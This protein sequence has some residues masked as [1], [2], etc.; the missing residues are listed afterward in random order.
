MKKRIISLIITIL[1]CMAASLP[2]FADNGSV[3]IKA[4]VTEYPGAVLHELIWTED[5]SR[6]SMRTLPMIASV[7]TKI[8][9]TGEFVYN[10][11]LYLKTIFNGTEGYIKGSTVTL[12][13]SA[14]G[15]DSAYKTAGPRSIAVIS[16]DGVSLRKGPSLAYDTVSEPFG[17]GT[18]FT[19]EYVDTEYEPDARWAYVT[20]DDVSGWVYI[21]Q[22]AMGI[23]CD[24]AKVLSENDYYTGKIKTIT[25]GAYLTEMPYSASEKVSENIPEKT[26]FDFKYYYENYDSI[27]VF[28]EYDG[29]KGWIK[30][31]NSEDYKAALGVKSGVCVFKEGGLPIYTD[32]FDESSITGSSLSQNSIAS[33]DYT[34]YEIIKENEETKEKRWMH[35]CSDDAEGWICSDN[36]NDYGQLFSVADYIISNEEGVTLYAEPDEASDKVATVPKDGVVTVFYEKTNLIEDEYITW[37][38]TEYNGNGGWMLFKAENLEYIEG[39]EAFT[40]MPASSEEYEPAELTESL[41]DLSSG[42]QKNIKVIAAVA[43]VCVF[44]A[45]I[46]AVIVIIIRKK[47]KSKAEK[48]GE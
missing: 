15:Q 33:V 8:S 1:V 20:S 6:N 25:D 2:A 11:E 13:E 32:A 12:E 36:R 27:M 48:I 24:F 34:Y 21:Y 44:V 38:F 28:V 5:Y 29:V 9:I 18:V 3:E 47:K 40:E 39:S 37:L 7:N 17:Y 35:I 41:F 26:V 31:D 16:K 10:G 23:N 22:F 46:V 19:Y 43:I 30:A 4:K 42:N 14:V 45:A